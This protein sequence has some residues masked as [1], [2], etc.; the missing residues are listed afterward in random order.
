MSNAVLRREIHPE[1]RVIDARNGI[2]EYIASDETLDQQGEVV[3]VKGW[4][5]TYFQKN[6]PF[7]DSHNYESIKS[8]L[9]K[10]IDFRVERNRLIETV[11]WAINAGNELAEV[12]FKM[13]AQGFLKAVSVGFKS[14]RSVTKGDVNR[15]EWLKQLKELNLTE[16]S[17]VWRI[18]MEQEQLELSACVM[19]CN[20]NALAKAHKAGVIGDREVEMVSKGWPKYTRLVH[21]I[22]RELR[23]SRS[24]DRM[25]T[26]AQVDA[27][28]K[29]CA[30]NA[31]QIYRAMR[32]AGYDVSMWTPEGK[33]RRSP[34]PMTR[35]EFLRRFEMARKGL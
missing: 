20:P 11:Q 33:A 35:G 1:V 26:Q 21:A 5:F 3:R 2:N 27:I 18:H 32:A 8:V 17:G 19:G 28:R 6:A 7:V 9:G 30:A 4:R 25:P 24:S 34:E 22:R 31:P 14:I 23:V 10:V 16:D 29:Q 12:G 13:A 15:L